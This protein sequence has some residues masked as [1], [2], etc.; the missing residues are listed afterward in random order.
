M[1]LRPFSRHLLL[2]TAILTALLLLTCFYNNHVGFYS[3]NVAFKRLHRE[4][5]QTQNLF[6]EYN[7]GLINS[8]G[9]TIMRQVYVPTGPFMY[10]YSSGDKASETILRSGMWEQ[11]VLNELTW[12]M[13]TSLPESLRSIRSNGPRT[14]DPAEWSDVM[15]VDA[16][17]K[18]GW[19]ALNIAARGYEVL[20]F[21]GLHQ[22]QILLRSTLCQNPTLMERVTLYPFALGAQHEVCLAQSRETNQGQGL[23]ANCSY[24]SS[25]AGQA[26]V[27][28]WYATKLADGNADHAQEHQMLEVHR[29]DKLLNMG[30]KV[31]KVDEDGRE[32]KVIQGAAQ[33]FKKYNVWFLLVE[34]H[35]H[36]AHDGASLP[37]TSNEIEAVLHF[38][39]E[40][41]SHGFHVSSDGFQGPYIGPVTGRSSEGR[42]TELQHLVSEMRS[43]DTLP[44]FY[45]YFVN[46]KLMKA[47]AKEKDSQP[48]PT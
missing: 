11:E 39:K 42:D 46:S 43:G 19:H 47:W 15:F 17:A 33:L 31:L 9:V 13:I 40:V 29:L 1:G 35:R 10:L 34:Y 5:R 23:V 44:S 14:D 12:A 16:G 22:N 36:L 32:L 24:V 37:T 30:V 28:S 8:T 2:F 18:I 20:A 38:L 25:A 21:E 6:C 41:M 3:H 7:S 26:S 4:C 48:L 27:V 45:F